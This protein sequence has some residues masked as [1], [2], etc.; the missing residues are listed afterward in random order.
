[1]NHN[2]DPYKKMLSN[3]GF[4]ESE[5][6]INMLLDRVERTKN[7]DL[8]PEMR[9]ALYVVEGLAFVRSSLNKVQIIVPGFGSTTEWNPQPPFCCMRAMNIGYEEEPIFP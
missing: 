5:L 9:S 6:P 7:E 3:P 1:M 8:L 2:T 4:A